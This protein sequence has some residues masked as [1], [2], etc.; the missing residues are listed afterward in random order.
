MFGRETRLGGSHKPED[1]TWAVS[2][3]TVTAAAE[4]WRACSRFSDGGIPRPSPLTSRH[5][6]HDRV[7][8]KSPVTEKTSEPPH[9]PGW[10]F[11]PPWCLGSDTNGAA[12]ARQ[13][14]P[15]FVRGGRDCARGGVVVFGGRGR[16][17][18]VLR[19]PAEP[20]PG[21]GSVGRG[22]EW[23]MKSCRYE[24]PR[25]SL[26]RESGYRSWGLTRD[27][28]TAVHCG[29]RSAPAPPSGWHPN[30]DSRIGYPY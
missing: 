3:K 20:V 29:A 1:K 22:A 15:C 30:P 23:M 2:L 10:R 7:G 8:S 17:F 5:V 11:S 26:L 24:C 9:R 4:T 13:G 25:W 21:V 19:V 18:Q 6:C 28:A 14:G 27:P 16:R 12:G